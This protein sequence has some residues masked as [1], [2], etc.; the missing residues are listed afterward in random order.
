MKKRISARIRKCLAHAASSVDIS[1][2]LTDVDVRE[3]YAHAFQIESY[4]EFWTRVLTLSNKDSAKSVQVESTKTAR[5]SSYRL[6]A[7]QLLD[8][9]QS[10]VIRILDLVKTPSLIY[11]YFTETANASLLFGLY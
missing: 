5:I 3:E 4:N 10:T 11:D 8:L 7:E 1:N 2:Q 9:D 6:F